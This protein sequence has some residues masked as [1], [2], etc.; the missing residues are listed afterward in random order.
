MT[1]EQAQALV[2]KLTYEQKLALNEMLKGLEQM[3][4]PSESRPV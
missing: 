1:P 3:R 4:Q 2:S